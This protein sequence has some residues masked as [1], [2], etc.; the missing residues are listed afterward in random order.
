MNRKTGSAKRVVP[1]GEC[2]HQSSKTSQPLNRDP[3]EPRS[4]EQRP[5]PNQDSVYAAGGCDFLGSVSSER[6]GDPAFRIPA[7]YRPVFSWHLP[8]APKQSRVSPW[9]SHVATGAGPLLFPCRCQRRFQPRKP[10]PQT[11]PPQRF[12]SPSSLPPLHIRLPTPRT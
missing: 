12:D 5:H 9:R 8:P 11:T 6:S 4:L 3:P 10:R 7:L 1:V 2:D